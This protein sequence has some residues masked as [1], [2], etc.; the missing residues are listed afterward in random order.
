MVL[1]CM[2]QA[3]GWAVAVIIPTSQ[4]PALV[5]CQW[6]ALAAA[7]V[8]GAVTASISFFFGQC[9]WLLLLAAQQ[10]ACFPSVTDGWNAGLEPN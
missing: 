4:L 2:R 6:G 7:L 3:A 1:P 8:L 9:T 10:F 5:V